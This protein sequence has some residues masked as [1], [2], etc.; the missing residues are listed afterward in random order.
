M[1][2]TTAF[3][4]YEKIISSSGLSGADIAYRILSLNNIHD[5][6]IERVRGRLTDHFDPSAKILR[7]SEPVFVSS[8]RTSEARIDKRLER[9]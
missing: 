3:S 4:K 7:L 5:V 8:S 6:K 1:R 2:V 9:M